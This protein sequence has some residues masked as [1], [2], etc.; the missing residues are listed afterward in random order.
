[1]VPEASTYAVF[2]K[3]IVKKGNNCT[4]KVTLK[5]SFYKVEMSRY[6]LRSFDIIKA[7]IQ[8]CTSC[9]VV[10]LVHTHKRLV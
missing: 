2:T 4:L 9:K 1:M 6:K 8:T 5:F 10:S 7:K 3:P